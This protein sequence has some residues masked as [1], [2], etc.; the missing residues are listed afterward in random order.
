M[1]ILTAATVRALRTPGQFRDGQG[2]FLQVETGERRH[3]IFRYQRQGR[4]RVMALG[5]A[6]VISLADARKLH[7]EARASL[8]KGIDPL[9]ARHADKPQRARTFAEVVEEY[10]L[11]HRAGWRGRR[12]ESAWRQSLVTHAHRYFGDKPV[13]VIAL[14]DV[15]KALQAIWQAKPVVA[16]HVRNRIELV[17]DYAKARRWRT[18]ENPAVWRGNLKMLLPSHSKFHTVEHR[19]AMPWREA[20]SF[21]VTLQG[22]DGMA[23]R[24]LAFCILTAVRS[25]EARG[26]RWDEIDMATATWTIPASRTKTGKVHR[27]PLS[28]P[29]MTILHGIAAVRPPDPLVFFTRAPGRPLADTTLAALLHKLG[30]G[31]VTTH[32][33]R[34]AFRDWAADTGQSDPAA[35]A[36]LAHAAGSAV[37]RAY[38]HSDLLDVRRPMM[39]AWAAFLGRQTG[40]VVALPQRA[41]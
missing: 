4:G 24:C 39:A 13:D 16:A 33:F 30:H 5:N 10:I 1:G 2:L 34:S 7:T 22:E 37:V 25:A 20:P 9:D 6:D 12:T 18:G 40:T 23:A 17:L 14:D 8:A 27:V 38:K 15:L 21:M 41:A 3:W 36:A 11:A 31:D 32:G 26:A 28:E 19:A 29:A 35:E